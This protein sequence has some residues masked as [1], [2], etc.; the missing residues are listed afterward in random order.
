MGYLDNAG[1][2]YF[3]GKV[4]AIL[5]GGSSGGVPVG[6][7]VIWS[8][9]AEDIPD[10]W[11]L[12]DGQ[13]GRP[14]LRDKFVLGAGTAHAVGATGGEE[15]H[16]L[17]VEEMPTHSHRLSIGQLNTTPY[18]ATAGTNQNS[19]GT[20]FESKG[21]GG[22]QPHNNMPPY[23][24][25]CYIIKTAEDSGGGGASGES[26]P[27]GT[28]ISFMGTSA[29]EGYLVCDGA[30]YGISQYP[31]LAS[32]FQAQ[33]GT[34][35]HFGGDGT[36]TFAV[37][38]MRNLFLRGYHGEAE[39]Q[40]SGEIGAKQ[41]ATIIPWIGSGGTGAPTGRI[42][43]ISPN[44]G[45]A[46][47]PVYPKNVDVKSKENPQ[48]YGFCNGNED[49]SPSPND[50]G[51]DSYSYTSRP[52]NMAVL[53]CIKAVES[54]GGGG[55]GSAGEAYSTEEQ[56]IGTWT[57]GKPLYRRVLEGITPATTNLNHLILDG[58]HIDRIV[59]FS[60]F[61][62]PESA[63]T[64]PIVYSTTNSRANIYCV[65]GTSLFMF[66]TSAANTNR[67]YNVIIEYTKTTD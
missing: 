23:Y 54:S 58:L 61:V 34:K 38:D 15:T 44:K 41:E 9:T 16:T 28:V 43:W 7:I 60:G 66:M 52:V 39:E 29:P 3:W 59:N 4:K 40:L 35:N 6:T 51:R 56:V 27:I 37:P 63:Y 32:F 57:D 49:L 65:S 2:A 12:C 33:F 30:E 64:E 42:Y 8:G 48:Y 25:L 50:A 62:Y 21:T 18:I 13:D 36:A 10:G 47:D 67:P 22:S 45:T 14:D 53:Y 5:P 31:A 46:L 26:N 11:A 19:T 20:D 17:T 24:A 1:L 55:G